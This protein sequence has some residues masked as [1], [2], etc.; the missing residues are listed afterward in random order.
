MNSD[1]IITV[2]D[3]PLGE[4]EQ[5]ICDYCNDPNEI[6]VIVNHEKDSAICWSCIRKM[7]EQLDRLRWIH[8]TDWDKLSRQ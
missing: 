1:K 8:A 5:F 2:M 7:N 4:D 3:E 6:S